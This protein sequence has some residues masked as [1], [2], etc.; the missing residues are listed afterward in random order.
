MLQNERQADADTETETDEIEVTD[1]M[2][3]AGLL[4]LIDEQAAVA[5]PWPTEDAVKAAY[6]VMRR[7]A[8]ERAA[9]PV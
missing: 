7:M 6:R 5:S 9:K 2:A 4:A 3:E 1:E 8:L